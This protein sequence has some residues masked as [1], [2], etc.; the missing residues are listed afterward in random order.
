VRIKVIACEVIF[1]EV[2]LCAA[3]AKTVIDL[4]FLRRGLHSNPDTLREA[5]QEVVDGT[6]ES[7]CQAIALGYALCSNG[8]AGLRA[9]G[10]PLVAPRAH[11]CIT[12]LVGSKE[13][14]AEEF[15]ARPGTYYY[16]GGWIERGADQVPRNPED[17]AGL[18]VPFEELVRKYG[19]DNAEYL[20]EIQSAWMQNYT[21]A[22]FIDVGLGKT[23][24]YRC[25]TRREAEQK[26]WSY[27]EMAGDLSL[28]QALLDGDWDEERFLITRPGQQIVPC[29]G[30]E[31]LRA[32]EAG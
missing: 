27:D 17:G 1:R 9:R 28:L 30:D 6:D 29:V 11:D 16:S 10:I 7:R 26:A 13:R 24:E 23:E 25:Y 18:D 8:V 32:E 20:W 31:I 3:R 4:V 15:A 19:Q 14:Y 2:C 22:M 21:H 12:L 5:V